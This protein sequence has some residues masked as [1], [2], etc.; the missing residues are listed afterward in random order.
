[1]RIADLSTVELQRLGSAVLRAY[2]DASAGREP[3]NVLQ[4]GLPT[5]AEESLGDLATVPQAAIGPVTVA[6]QSDDQAYVAAAVLQPGQKRQRT[7]V[8]LAAELTTVDGLLRVARV[9]H[10]V[11]LQRDVDATDRW[12]VDPDPPQHVTNILGALPAS[13]EARERWVTAAAVI[14]EYRQTWGITDA[15]LAL[16]EPPRDLG[17]REERERAVRSVRELLSEIDRAS[18][19]Q[20]EAG[21]ARPGPDL[22]R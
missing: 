12:I 9:G 21:R 6:R 22:A 8:L 19:V 4:Q 16:G 13:E 10:C 7:G 1:V 3:T 17:Q 2:V 18:L 11:P 5:L 14:S 20:D 15:R